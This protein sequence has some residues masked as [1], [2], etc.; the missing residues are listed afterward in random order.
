MLTADQFK[1][2]KTCRLLDDA[3]VVALGSEDQGKRTH[4]GATLKIVEALLEGL[5]P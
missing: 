2:R 1:A 4:A 3:L 5:R